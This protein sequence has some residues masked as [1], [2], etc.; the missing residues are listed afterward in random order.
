MI[1][2]HALSARLTTAF[3]KTIDRSGFT[4]NAMN[5]RR[6][7]KAIRRVSRL[8][9]SRYLAAYLGNKV[10]HV[11]LRAVRS[12]RVA[13]PST[14]MLEVTNLCN[15][16]C[17]TCA[18]QYAYG[19]AMDKGHMPVSTAQK[20]IDEAWPCLDSIGL[21]GLGEPFLYEPLEELVDYIRAKNSGIVTSVSTN[22]MVPHFTDRVARVKDRIDTIQVSMDGLGQV[23]ESIRSKARFDRFDDNLRALARMCAR[24]DTSVML[25]MVVTQQNY[26]QMTDVVA[27]AAE[28]GIAYC[29][30]ALFNLAAVT[31]IDASYYAF[32]RSR[33]FRTA[34]QALHE[35][36]K[37]Y[38]D[39][40]VTVRHFDT[41]KGFRTCS[42]PW[43]HFYITWDG[44][45]VPC[46]AKPFPKELNFGN[47]RNRRLIDVLNSD[48]FRH[49]RRQWYAN[50]T[51]S[52]CEKCHYVAKQP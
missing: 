12:T 5:K 40:T 32:Y 22:A 36:Q 8:P 44:Y 16:A 45:V 31:G 34:M 33:P 30:F 1:F 25:N 41:Q 52:F 9:R 13:W 50:T 39:V 4:V 38:P 24:S 17:T 46:C 35:A 42:F 37:R 2:E 11:C 28:V 21:T 27:Y 49:F 14:I 20:V 10:R 6:L 3:I 48:G 15:L 47:V 26:H 43:T 7:K 18:R 23:Y 19:R 29:D 51:P